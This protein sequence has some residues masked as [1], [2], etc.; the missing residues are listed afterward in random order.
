MKT[1][2][3]QTDYQ[4]PGT[5]FVVSSHF[6]DGTDWEGMKHALRFVLRR[7]GEAAA[8][9]MVEEVKR[10][11]QERESAVQG[12]LAVW[13]VTGGDVDAALLA[14]LRAKHN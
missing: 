13:R 9:E 6:M 4:V 12:F 14:V 3:Y 5:E 1:P 2:T 8:R 10:R 7:C 11:V